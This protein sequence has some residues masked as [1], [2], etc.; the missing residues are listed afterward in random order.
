MSEVPSM[1]FGARGSV[2]ASVDGFEDFASE[3]VP[4]VARHVQWDGVV[5]LPAIWVML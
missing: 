3:C 1:A 4:P 5:D 2:S